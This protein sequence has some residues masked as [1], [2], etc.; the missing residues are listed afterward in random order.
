MMHRENL[1]GLRAKPVHGEEQR[2]ALH[3]EIL[4]HYRIGGKL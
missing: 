4:L 2:Q 3:F 1:L